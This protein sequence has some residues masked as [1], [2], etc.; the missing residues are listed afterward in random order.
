V[1]AY[2]LC[3]IRGCDLR[4]AIFLSVHSTEELAKQ[5]GGEYWRAGLLGWRE[6]YTP[7]KERVL[8]GFDRWDQPVL[9]IEG[10]HLE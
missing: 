6:I 3:L 10:T 4:C 1:R 2:A 5:R 9:V 7:G 8:V